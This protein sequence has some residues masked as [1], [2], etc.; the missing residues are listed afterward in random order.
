MPDTSL[1]NTSRKPWWA[2]FALAV[3]MLT[4]GL[5]ITVLT[6][7]LPTLAVQLGATPAQ[8]QWFTTA[9]TLV[10]A[11]ALLPAGAL[12]DRFGRKKLL[13]GALVL[14]GIAS[15]ACAYAGSSGQLIAA[16]AVLGLAAAAMMPLSMAVLPVLFPYPDDRSRAFTVWVTATAIGLPLGP[17]LGGWLLQHFWWGSVF[18]INV[19]LVV[20]GACA[21]AVLVP[22]SRSSEPVA[23]DG[24]GVVLSGL[25][26]TALTYGFIR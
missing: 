20:I 8:L 5:D 14:F 18:L 15:L 3:A 21:V 4:I 6:V 13:L 7:A 16:R 9:Y 2:L 19:P 1:S 11:A 10:L 17:I 24:L 25:G 23:I 22:E 26:L 12:G